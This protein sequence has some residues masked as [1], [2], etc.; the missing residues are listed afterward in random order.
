M[1]NADLIALGSF[2]VIAVGLFA[3]GLLLFGGRQNQPLASNRR[4]VFG[5]LTHLLA[6]SI[7]VRFESQ[8]S[9]DRELVRAGY[10]HRYARSEYLAT[11]NVLVLGWLTLIAVACV[12]VAEPGSQLT[13]PILILGL[14]VAV[15]LFSVPRLILQAQ[16]GG[17]LRRIQHALPDALDML[18]MTMVGGLPL[19]QAVEH[20][21]KEI[22]EVY[23][24]LACELSILQR[25]IATSSLE[26]ALERFAH[27]IDLPDVQSLAA[28]IA[29]TER[30]G[31]NVAQAFSDYAD[32][33]RRNRR[34]RAEA[35]GNRT[36][37]AMILPIVLCLAPPIY[38]LLIGP[39]VL[40]LR[41]FIVEGTRDGGLL[42]PDIDI[43]SNQDFR[44]NTNAGR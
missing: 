31:A 20:V 6:M 3:M 13:I 17:R 22:A 10:Y 11:R 41:S 21:S 33:V 18:T 4:L 29:Q 35:H 19:Q 40:E 12:V 38:I 14:V 27:R 15:I 5:R 43:Q 2:A 32:N 1:N 37:V 9:L 8:E 42:R 7:P 34:Q 25:H 23:P 30:L 39:A 24:D 28:L 44:N 26:P 16:A 36:S